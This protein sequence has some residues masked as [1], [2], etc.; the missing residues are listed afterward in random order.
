MTLA[1]LLLFI[2]VYAL[3]AFSPG[4]AVAAMVAR[5]LSRG[6]RGAAA[7]ILGLIAGDLTWLVAASSGLGLIA[8]TYAPLFRAI[9][10][11]GAAYLLFM[12]VMMWRAEPAPPSE[13]RDAEAGQGFSAF[14]AAFVLTLGNPK[15]MVFFLSIMP[16]VLS[17]DQLTPV[18]V[19]ELALVCAVLL[20]VI[21]TGYVLLAA[22]ARRL[23]T[24]R[25]A[26]RRINRGTA[27]VM[28]GT[29]AIV[30]TR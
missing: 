11:A 9:Q 27:G 20:G 5:T 19:A 12:A 30:A 17:P 10:Y 23:F 14:L 7:F 25:T 2:P 16:L 29:A 6:T 26:L 4:P 13:A 28:A 21:F 8:Q 24:S 1:A 22:R 3:A 18:A 15:T